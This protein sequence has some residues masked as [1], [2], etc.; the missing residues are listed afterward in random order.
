MLP[1]QIRVV[2]VYVGLKIFCNNNVVPRFSVVYLVGYAF[3]F[4]LGPYLALFPGRSLRGLVQDS[5]VF[6]SCSSGPAQCRSVVRNPINF[7]LSVLD[8]IG[9]YLAVIF[10]MFGMFKKPQP[11]STLVPQDLGQASTAAWIFMPEQVAWDDVIS[12]AMET[13]QEQMGVSSG[14]R[15]FPRRTLGEEGGAVRI[16]KT[17]GDEA[18]S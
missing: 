14:M 1:D 12:V 9:C 6:H 4:V 15:F 7:I 16:T 3:F 8:F 18:C 10:G 11:R 13:I 2:N 5:R 17:P